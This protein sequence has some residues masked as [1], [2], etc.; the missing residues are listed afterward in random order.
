[1]ARY[2]GRTKVLAIV[3]AGGEGKRLMPLTADRAKPAVPFGGMYRLIDFAL[4][5]IVNSGYLKIVVL[6]QYKSHSLDAH[7]T[8]TWRMSTLL[9]N[10]VAPVPA[11]QRRGKQWYQGS[12][13]AIYQS[14]NL[15]HDERPDIVVVVGADH[16]YRMDF[17]QMVAQHEQTGAG[18]TV[19]AIRQP[20]SLADQFGVIDVDPADPRRIHEFLEKPTDPPGL[21][22]SPEEVLA[23]MGNYVFDA[24]VLERAVTA[25]AARDGSK[26]DMGGDIVPAFVEA[27]DAW[28][29]DFK[30][31][32]IPGAT[33]RD[34]AYWRDVG[35]L[36]SYYDAHMDLV[37]IHPVFNLYN[38]AWPIYTD[39]GSHPPAKFVHGSKDRIG[40]AVNSAV[41]NGVVVSGASVTGSVLSPGVRVHSFSSI[42]DSVLMDGVDVGRGC[43]VHRAIVDKNVVVPPGTNLGVDHEQ[44]R[45]RGLT[46]TDSGLVVVGKGTV[47]PG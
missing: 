7:V 10:Y 23:S 14:L 13:D 20:R 12:A 36:D 15:L 27:G 1:M 35:T 39:P 16:V 28:V 5:N 45:A 29:Y 30:D 18:V 3:L 33:D 8:K 17:S 34:R 46:V 32:D 26:H 4:S 2:P 40:T 41:S 21:P 22:D 11:Q 38:E 44:D 25:D 42:T 43:Q 47:L 19:A 37:S 31:N 6:T 9:G 24:D